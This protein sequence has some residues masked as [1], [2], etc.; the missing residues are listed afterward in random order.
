M[1]CLHLPLNSSFPLKLRFI[2]LLV[3][4]FPQIEIQVNPQTLAV[5]HEVGESS[6]VCVYR[7]ARSLKIQGEIQ[8]PK[9]SGDYLKII[10]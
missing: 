9:T 1:G 6:G 8:R 4:L 3:P 10:H 2:L 7:A 5:W